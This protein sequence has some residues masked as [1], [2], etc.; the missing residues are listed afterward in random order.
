M[1]GAALDVFGPV[2]HILVG[3]EDQVLRTGHVMFPLAFAHVVHRAVR[4]VGM[5]R[6]VSVF[7]FADDLVRCKVVVNLEI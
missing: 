1:V 5:V 4:L 7:F 6:N 3:V 2:A